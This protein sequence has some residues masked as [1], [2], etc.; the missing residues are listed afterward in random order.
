MFNIQ[1][2][3]GTQSGT[4]LYREKVPDSHRLLL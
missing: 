2:S 4:N 3:N 1:F